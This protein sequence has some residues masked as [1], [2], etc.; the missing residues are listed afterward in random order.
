MLARIRV[1]P[2][3]RIA[4]GVAI[5]LALLGLV[6]ARVDPASVG[7]AIARANPALVGLA[8]LGSVLDQTIRASRWR[9]ILRPI[10]SIPIVSAFAFQSIGYLANAALPARLGDLARAHLAGTAFGIPRLASLGSIVAE[11][12]LDGT[13]M[14]ALAAISSVFVARAGSVRELVGYVTAVGIAALAVLVMGWVILRKL[15]LIRSGRMSLVRGLWQRVGLGWSAFRNP[16]RAAAIIAITLFIE[17]VGA[18]IAFIVTGSVGIQLSPLESVLLISALALSL[19][20]PAAPGG[21]GTYEFAGMT[22]LSVLGYD[23]DSSLAALLI[24][25]AV[26]T[27]PAVGF[28]L[29][30]LATLGI[31]PSS[32]LHPDDQLASN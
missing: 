32:I 31:R 7:Q 12:L 18:S 20:I 14:L 17:I 25:R 21:W 2:R 3:V 15:Q 19:A 9:L 23:P 8:V 10:R 27:L 4:L 26:T 28:G 11:R 1:T 13:A 5:S 16:P 30:S 24:L 22:V 6:V 29:I